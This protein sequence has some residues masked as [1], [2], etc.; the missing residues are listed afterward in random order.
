MTTVA[1]RASRTQPTIPLGRRTRRTILVAHIVSAASWIGIDVVVAILIATSFLT[2]S[3]QTQAVAYQVLG[4]IAVWPMFIAGATCLL[5]GVL[6]GLGT[7]YGLVRTWWVTIKLCLNIALTTLVLL[8][9]R[10]GVNDLGDYG[11]GV[12]AGES[13]NPVDTSTLGFPPSVSLTMLTVA[14]VLSV[15]KPWGRIR[16][17]PAR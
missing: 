16:R 1:P 12:L 7:K 6:L 9:L 17:R 8:A 4:M 11:R 14:V 2:D 5:T 10:P 15:F 3:A 13:P